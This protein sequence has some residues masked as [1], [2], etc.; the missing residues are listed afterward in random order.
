[1]H[2]LKK[3]T[4]FFPRFIEVVAMIK[5]SC[6]WVFCTIPVA[7]ISMNNNKIGDFDIVRLD[8]SFKLLLDLYAAV[9]LVS[10]RKNIDI[11]IC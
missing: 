10:R 2:V 6:F 8:K 9:H 3:K 7:A 1:M 4:I 11:I 5:I